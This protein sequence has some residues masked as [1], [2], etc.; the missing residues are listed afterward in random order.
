[1]GKRSFL[2][3]LY[4]FFFTTLSS[5]IFSI[6]SEKYSSKPSLLSSP[7]LT[8]TIVPQDTIDPNPTYCT[9]VPYHFTGNANPGPILF[10]QWACTPSTG[11]TISTP[12]QNGTDITFSALGSYTITVT[13][14]NSSGIVGD[15]TYIINAPGVLQTP[16]VSTFPPAPTVC[17]GGTGTVLYAYAT[18]VAGITTYTWSPQ[19]N[20]TTLDVN[21]DSVNVNPSTL[22]PPK[23]YTYTVIGMQNGCYS[24]PVAITVTVTTPPVPQYTVSPDPIC[25]KGQTVLAVNGM[26]SNTTYTWSQTNGNNGTGGIGGNSGSFVQATPV[27]YGATDTIFTYYVQVD[28]QGCP[29]YSPHSINLLVHPTPVI[30]VTDTIQDCNKLGDTL[31]ANTIY[32]ATG[33]NLVWTNASGSVISPLAS[34]SNS[35]F[36]NP[37]KNTTSIKPVT[38]YVTPSINYGTMTCTGK[39][40]SIAVV[41]GDTTNASVG[42]AY[43]IIC[44]GQLNE[45][46]AYPAN[47][48]LNNSYHYTWAPQ[49]N[50]VY[51]SLDGDTVVI[52]PTATTTYTLDVS[53]ICVNKK[54]ALQTISVNA[55]ST[56]T[57]NFTATSHTICVNHCITYTDITNS[58][59]PLF[60]TWVFPGG[61]IT[62]AG[63][64]QVYGG[65]SLFYAAVDSTPIKS[66]KVCYPVNSLLNN[67]GYYPVIEYVENGLQYQLGTTFQQMPSKTDSIQVNPGPIAMANGG[68]NVT[69]D[70]GTSVT[71][72]PTGSTGSSNII[73]YNWVS[74]A[75]S[76]SCA[77]CP[78]PVVTPTTTTEYTLTIIDQT[79][80]RSSASIT[81]F[82]DVICKDAFIA[83]AF[84]PNGD[85]VNDVLHVKSNCELS[86]FSFKIFDRWGEKVFESSDPNYGWDGT[87]RNKPVDTGVF[88]Y[89]VDGFLS[90]GVEVK[91]KGNVTLLR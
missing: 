90:S 27:Y 64:G 15:T 52:D 58:V 9:D 69:V 18:P 43:S 34:D 5:N 32:P 10:W 51:T 72:N 26:P 19:T 4:V 22:S 46:V 81:V 82:V 8:V 79:G 20:L 56:P 62:N 63:G 60:Y 24:A 40:D 68:N 3:V 47:N 50:V 1:M 33:V 85:G 23:T 30:T 59:K 86:T 55:C 57:V 73:S 67:N 84:S 21:G 88:I 53:G 31:K 44:S 6:N 42:Y 2:A 28:L 13:A 7:T 66:I 48:Q 78:S 76:I 39:T 29:P 25:S 38:Y 36:V 17:N 61:T 70:L 65:D 14:T 80:C 89:T 49:A 75:D 45:L 77:S 12:L 91:K 71:L 41:I 83:T 37:S 11:V 74:S 16:V 87:Y 54:Q 35:I